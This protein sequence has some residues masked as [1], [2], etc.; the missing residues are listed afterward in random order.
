MLK[1]HLTFIKQVE[2]LPREIGKKDKTVKFDKKYSS[3]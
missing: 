2:K 1:A 3:G